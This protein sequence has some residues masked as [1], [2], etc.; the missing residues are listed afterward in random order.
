MKRF[1]YEG[2]KATVCWGICDKVIT[3]T[4]KAI[5]SKKFNTYSAM[6]Y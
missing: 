3:L 1:V 6:A 2:G 5:V 4:I